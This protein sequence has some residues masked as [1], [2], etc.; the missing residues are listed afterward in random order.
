MGPQC[1]VFRGLSGEKE[2]LSISKSGHC[3]RVGRSKP[4][5]VPEKSVNSA[6]EERIGKLDRLGV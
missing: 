1:P 4:A 6:N 5:V 3:V 2:G